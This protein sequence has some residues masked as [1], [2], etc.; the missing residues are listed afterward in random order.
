M[1]LLPPQMANGV[2]EKRRI[3]HDEC[4][5]HTGKEKTAD[6]THHAVI[7][8]A[9]EKRAGQ[10]CEEQERIVL[11][12]PD[13]NGIVRDARRIFRIGMSIGDKEPSTVAMPKPL[14]RIV[15]IFFLVTV[16]VMTQMIGGPF[17]GGVLKRPGASDQECA[18]DP[19]R[20]VKAS[21]G[22]QSMVADGDTQSADGIEQSKHRPVEPAVVI[23]ISIE[24][25]SD[26]GAQG[27]GA[28]EDDGPD[29][30]TT[31]DLDRCTLGGDR[32]RW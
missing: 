30:T 3:K 21:M 15:R 24:R 26:H 29:S 16:R 4:A 12:L 8:K 27:N 9:D 6:S 17:D 31:A 19:I 23:E 1:W 11:V 20:A 28:K 7:E 18:F 10:A 5:S 14:L 22:H 25:D 2:D 13:R 32:K